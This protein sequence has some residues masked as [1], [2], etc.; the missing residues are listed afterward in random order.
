MATIA[1]KLADLRGLALAVNPKELRRSLQGIHLLR[2]HG[3]N[4][5]TLTATDGKRLHSLRTDCT[6]GDKIDGIIPAHLVSAF[7]KV[8]KKPRGSVDDVLSIA[9]ERTEAI[10]GIKRYRITLSG[11]AGN[12]RISVSALDLDEIYPP[13]MRVIPTEILDT[14]GAPEGMVVNPSHAADA[15]IFCTGE[16]PKTILPIVW[17][18]SAAPVIVGHSVG[19]LAAAR[20]YVAGSPGKIAVAVTVRA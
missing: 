13:V 16:K 20:N 18:T 6:V 12:E 9:I 8:H 5:V 7:L 14:Q 19:D 15:V 4:M 2:K 3:S 11:Y 1:I 17:Q 10:E